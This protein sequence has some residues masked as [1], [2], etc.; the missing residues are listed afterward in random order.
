MKRKVTATDI[1]VLRIVPAVPKARPGGSRANAFRELI[2]QCR[3]KR[4]RLRRYQYGWNVYPEQS[5][6]I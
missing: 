2:I 3:G 6:S 1:R 4:R 5:A